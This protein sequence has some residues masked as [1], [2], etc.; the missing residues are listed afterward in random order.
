VTTNGGRSWEC[1]VAGTFQAPTIANTDWAPAREKLRELLDY[2]DATA[3][4]D[5]QAVVYNAAAGKFKPGTVAASGG[6]T[7]PAAVTARYWALFDIEAVSG[8]ALVIAEAAFRTVAGGAGVVPTAISAS[9]GTATNLN[10]SVAGNLDTGVTTPSWIQWDFGAAITPVEFYMI[11]RTD[12]TLGYNQMPKTMRLCYSSDGIRWSTHSSYTPNFTAT[13]Q[14]I[15][16]TIPAVSANTQGNAVG[17]H[18]YWALLDIAGQHVGGANTANVQF[19]DIQFYSDAAATV[20][21]TQPTFSASSE[22]DNTGTYAAANLNVVGGTYWAASGGFAKWLKADF[23]AP[24]G[25]A[26]FKITPVAGSQTE[27]PGGFTFAYSDDGLVWTPV[28]EHSA[29]GWVSGTLKTFSVPTIWQQGGSGGGLVKLAQSVVAVA[30]NSIDFSGI[31]AGY[32]DLLIVMNGQLSGSADFVVVRC[33]ADATSGNYQ[34]ARGVFQNSGLSY[35]SA[36]ATGLVIGLMG[37]AA[38]GASYA[39]M[40]EASIQ[41]YARTSF[42][43]NARGRSTL[44]SGTTANAMTIEEAVADWLSTAAINRLTFIANSGNFTVGTV[45]TIYGRG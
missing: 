45:I 41:S 38:A 6:S 39:D 24:V 12:Y 2:D 21:I 43:K 11:S 20:G 31:P 15:S 26:A 36:V 4:T 14:T 22:F 34:Y 37:G 33:N 8:Q 17:L 16:M 10:P 32:E 29:S 40:V 13:G 18:R 23:G 9:A 7:A 44:R 42:Y 1:L 25:V 3:P 5:G 28:S 19:Q 27:S 35:S 30:T